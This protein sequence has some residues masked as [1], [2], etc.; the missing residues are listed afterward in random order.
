MLALG[1]RLLPLGEV[2]KEEISF[3]EKTLGLGTQRATVLGCY[4]P[5]FLQAAR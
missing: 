1:H 3:G 5:G 2:R 4:S